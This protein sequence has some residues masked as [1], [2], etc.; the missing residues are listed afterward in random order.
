LES[1][2]FLRIIIEQASVPVV[3]DAGI[4]A[5]S[6]AAEAMEMGASA[7]LVNTA[8]AVSSDPVSMARAF[9]KAVEAGRMAHVAGLG[10]VGQNAQATS[11]LTNFLS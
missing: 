8:I 4:G 9:A 2:E 6:Q 3:V 5:P 7:V 10:G 1:R 11:P